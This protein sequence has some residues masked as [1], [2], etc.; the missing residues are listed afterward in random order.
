MISAESACVSLSSSWRSYVAM[1]APV[2]QSRRGER[3]LHGAQRGPVGDVEAELGIRLPGS[4]QPVRLRIDAG[5]GPYQHVLLDAL[6]P[7]DLRK[8]RQLQ[9]VIDDD[10]SD[11]RLDGHLQLFYGFVIPVQGQPLHRESCL[12]R[13][14]QLAKRRHVHRQSLFGDDGGHRGREERL[15]GVVDLVARVARIERGLVPAAVGADRRLVHHIERRA[16]LPREPD[17]VAAADLQMTLRV[18]AL[19]SQ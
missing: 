16:K 1:D 12:K 6:A 19:R 13:H 9:E 17:G 4:D 5:R 8:H 10:V 11:A 18:D 14:V 15:A 3:L 7:D 2:A